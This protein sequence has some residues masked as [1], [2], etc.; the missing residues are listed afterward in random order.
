M[1]FMNESQYRKKCN[2]PWMWNFDHHDTAISTNNLQEKLG[3]KP[4][5]HNSNLD[6]TTNNWKDHLWALRCKML[7]WTLKIESDTPDEDH[8]P[9]IALTD[10]YKHER[11][12]HKIFGGHHLA[13]TAGIAT[14]WWENPRGEM[15]AVR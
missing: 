15:Y 1:G 3:T 9:S 12:I 11:W 13:T 6:I 4:S 7:Y 14:T 10:F 2:E 8:F 5:H